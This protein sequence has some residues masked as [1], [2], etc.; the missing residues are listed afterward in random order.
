MGVFEKIHEKSQKFF[1][2]TLDFVS[3]NLFT[4]L[5]FKSLGLVKKLIKDH[6]SHTKIA[7]FF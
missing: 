7:N 5:K 3:S 1:F 4:F 6:L 2:K